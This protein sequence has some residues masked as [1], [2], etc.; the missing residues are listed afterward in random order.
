MSSAKVTPMD[1]R[2]RELVDRAMK[3]AIDAEVAYL[4]TKDHPSKYRPNETTALA[5][6][7]STYA[8]EV[9]VVTYLTHQ[10]EC[11]NVS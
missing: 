3:I 6:T 11:P 4:A 2:A 8:T 5:A 10:R 9:R 7:I 1:D